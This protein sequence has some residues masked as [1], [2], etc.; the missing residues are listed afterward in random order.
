MR[1]NPSWIT[2]AVNHRKYD[3]V[4]VFFGVIDRKWKRL[5]KQAVVICVHDA[6][7]SGSNPQT[8][9]VCFHSAYEIVSQP[10]FLRLV[11]V[12]TLIQ[13]PAR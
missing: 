1:S 8:L 7:A 4:L 6:V 2:S 11:K 13:I 9:N 5:A 3:D 10:D 12:E